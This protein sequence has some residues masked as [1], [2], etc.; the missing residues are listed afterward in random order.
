MMYGY[1][2]VHELNDLACFLLTCSEPTLRN[3]RLAVELATLACELSGRAP[4]YL[5]TLAA[6]F[7]EAGDFKAA[8]E[9]QREAIGLLSRGD[10]NEKDYRARLELYEAK[11]PFR[12]RNEKTK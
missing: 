8:G 10:R 7:A 3:R 2:S 12:I 4:D 5:V 9:T 1:G 11:R 6:S